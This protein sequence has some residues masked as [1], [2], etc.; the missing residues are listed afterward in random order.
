MAAATHLTT[1][2]RRTTV[3]VTDVRAECKF[4][5][6]NFSSKTYKFDELLQSEPFS[7]DSTHTWS[8]QLYPQGRIKRDDGYISVNL[9]HLSP[10]SEVEAKFELCLW[11]ADAKKHVCSGTSKFKG[12]HGLG[13]K[14]ISLA[15]LR[16][17]AKELL[18]DDTLTIGCQVS[19]RPTAK[20]TG[21]KDKITRA[22]AAELKALNSFHGLLNSSELSDVTLVVKGT[23]LNAHKFLLS[24][25][26]PVF[27]T[28]FSSGMLETTGRTVHITD[29]DVEVM[30]KFL[31]FVYTTEFTDVKQDAAELLVV[32]EKYSVAAL[33]HL[34]EDH[35][36]EE[37][38]EENAA[39]LLLLAH[40][41]DAADLR[42][43][44]ADFIIRNRAAV[45]RS[46]GWTEAKR[47]GGAVFLAAACEL[48][49]LAVARPGAMSSELR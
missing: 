6:K 33:K 1:T 15:T 24:A 23:E 3:T 10:K 18:P 32:A 2:W 35:L 8:V 46:E 29:V 26:S 4:I 22:R 44:A 40:V 9:Y 14:Y 20:T 38:S 16:E 27:A 30:K 5:I 12:V 7:T 45:M 28:M 47:A 36:S 49:E 37:L 25:R 39:A 42:R 21:N 31:H 11:S 34:C 17:Q 13:G 41:H 19:H 43:R 48:L